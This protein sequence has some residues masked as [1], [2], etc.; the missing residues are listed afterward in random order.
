[1]TRCQGKYGCYISR[2]LWVVYYLYV[3]EKCID[4]DLFRVLKLFPLQMRSKFAPFLVEIECIALFI[5]KSD[6]KTLE[7]AA[8]S[9]VSRM[10]MSGSK[11]SLK[12]LL[13][14][15]RAL[16]N[17]MLGKQD[18]YVGISNLAYLLILYLHTNSTLLGI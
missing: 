7:F 6:W 9:R 2:Y 14:E 8:S 12:C 15:H 16:Q 4:F 1:M 17:R 10:V 3:R 13:D 5:T 11:S 18:P